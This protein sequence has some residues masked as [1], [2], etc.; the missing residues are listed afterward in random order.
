LMLVDD[1][2]DLHVFML[3]RNP[4]SVFGP[5]AYVFPGGAIDPADSDEAVT[6]RVLGLDD[7]EAS[8]RLGLPSG[9]LRVWIG[10][11]R[12]TFEE[13][14]I[15]L[16]P[17]D[18]ARP[19]LARSNRARPNRARPPDAEPDLA[20]ERV[21]LNA[22]ELTFAEVLSR[23]G[24]ALD[25]SDVFLFA[26]W[27]TPEGAPRRYDTWFLIAPA[28]HGQEGSHDDAELVHSEWVRP[29][30]ALA[31]YA[32]GELDL[33]FPTL[34]TLR[35]L[36]SFDT[37]AALLDEVREANDASDRPPLVVAD[38]SGCHIALHGDGAATA[39]RGWPVL[40]S[41]PEVDMAA[42]LAEDRAIAREQGVA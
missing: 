16:A 8:A 33:I 40:T 18:L 7:R 1:R 22:G 6:T 23:S 9:G 38:A 4:R 32:A 20:A 28:P 5:G 25:L 30:D 27:L 14:G 34:R 24:L 10:A 37:A 12:E 21:R 13:A 39:A 41:K 2:P 42:L 26:H 31:R 3:R 29:A 35:V 11:L 36:A 17:A 15:L 19:D